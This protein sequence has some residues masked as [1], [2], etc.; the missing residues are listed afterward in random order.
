M[1]RT[2]SGTPAEFEKEI[3][4]RGSTDINSANRGLVQK[5]LSANGVPSSYAKSLSLTSLQG[6]YDDT[7]NVTLSSIRVM[8]RERATEEEL[9]ETEEQ[10]HTATTIVLDDRQMDLEEIVPTSNPPRGRPPA[11]QLADAIAAIVASSAA[12]VDEG[13]VIEL[14]KA[15]APKAKAVNFTVTV[16][17]PERPELHT[18][19][20]PRHAVF[21]E[22]LGAVAAGL[23]VLLVGPA[24]C[25]KT[26]VAEQVAEALG[27]SFR[28]TGAVSSEYKLLGF[29]DAQGRT[30]QTEY[31]R[32][33]ENGGL[34]LWDELDAS[35]PAAL[36]AFNAGLAN[37]HQDFPDAIVKRHENFRAIASANTYGNG[38][39]RL[40][41]GRNQ[42][43]AASLDRFYVIPMDYDT[44]LE[45]QLFGDSD[46]TDFCHRVRAAVRLLKLRHVVSMRAIDQ[47]HRA[48]AAGID[49]ATVERGALW[50]HLTKEDQ[51]KIRSQMDRV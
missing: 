3:G 2:P 7:T 10:G 17:L 14:I 8:A 26:H 32:A 25:G 21:K 30:V 41:V 37:G 6:V 11:R 47:G 5:W 28:F 27:A 23:N 31:R 38:A 29:V 15:H 40:Y 13:R 33:Y 48:L 9:R 16:K 1:A 22:L 50:K 4:P 24:G 19:D 36:L 39:D 34:F 49:R 42:L 51:V 45:R 43:D 44:T 35:A 12:P 20:A 18:P 46:W